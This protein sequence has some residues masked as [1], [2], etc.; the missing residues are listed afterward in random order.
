MI[1]FNTLIISYAFVCNVL[2]VI[3][4]ANFDDPVD[5]AQDI[6][7]RNLTLF[8]Q[9]Y[10][11]YWK[12]WLSTH[13]N[14]QY[15]KIGETMIIPDTYTQY[16]DLLINGLMRDNNHVFMRGYL[17]PSDKGYGLWWRSKEIIEGYQ[18]YTGYLSRKKWKHYEEQIILDIM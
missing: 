6:I 13:G 3:L 1:T 16:E 2:P 10:S 17:T 8:Y 7:D 15:R 4:R 9:P 12:Q 18:G 14:P 11:Y 5:F